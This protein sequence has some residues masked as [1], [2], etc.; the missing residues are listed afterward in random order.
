MRHS[1]LNGFYIFPDKA[2]VMSKQ[3]QTKFKRGRYR[4]ITNPNKLAAQ[5]AQDLQSVYAGLSRSGRGNGRKFRF[6]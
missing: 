2:A 3:L 6:K 4:T 5:L 1:P